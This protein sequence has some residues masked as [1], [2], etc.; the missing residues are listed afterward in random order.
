MY[1][2]YSAV[3]TWLSPFHSTDCSHMWIKAIVLGVFSICLSYPNRDANNCTF[4]PVIFWFFSWE[5]WNS[6]LFLVQWEWADDLVTHILLDGMHQKNKN[7]KKLKQEKCLHHKTHVFCRYFCACVYKLHYPIN[8]ENNP[9]ASNM[10]LSSRLMSLQ[11]TCRVH[12]L[13]CKSKV[14]T[15]RTTI[16]ILLLCSEH[17]EWNMQFGVAKKKS[18]FTCWNKSSGGH[19]DGHGWNTFCNQMTR[20][21]DQ[22]TAFPPE[23]WLLST[24]TSSKDTEEMES[25]FSS[26]DLKLSNDLR[27]WQII[28][29]SFV[30]QADWELRI[31]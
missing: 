15:S 11:L 20:L 8:L 6:D 4:F 29:C 1:A 19:Q 16:M 24:V 17:L 2:K 23:S 25:R 31:T 5:I 18:I 30:L 10:C 27:N 26:F 21:M 9:P 22:P 13:V 14:V 28:Y 7:Q 3:P 12:P